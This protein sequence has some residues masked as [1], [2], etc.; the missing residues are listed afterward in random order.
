MALSDSWLKAHHKKPHETAI[1]KAD[2]EGLGVRVS[3]TG[4]IVFQMRYRFGGKPARLDLG[5]YPLLSLREARTEHQRLRTELER[6]RDP[7]HVRSSEREEVAKVWTNEQLYREWHTNYCVE[8]KLQADD[9]LRSFEIHVFPKLGKLPA[10]QT[11]A[12]QWLTLIETVA[13]NTPSIAERIL[14]T[15]KQMQKWA[16][17]RGLM[18]TKPLIDVSVAEDLMIQ[19]EPAGR[20]LSEEEIRLFWYGVEA[21]RMAPGTKIFLKLLLLFGCRGVELRELDPVKD[22]DMEA[23]VW[24]VP[25]EKNK[26]RK[27]VRRGISR[28]IIQEIRPLIDEAK[29]HSRSSHL[30]FTQEK[31]PKPLEVNATLSMPASVMRNVKRVYGVEMKHWSLYDLRKTARTNFSTLTDVHVAEVMLGHALQGM[32]G[33]YDRHLSIEEQA[34]AYKKWWDRIMGIVATPP[35]RKEA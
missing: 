25:P 3:A 32:Q 10:D 14:Q 4:K 2:G 29:R 11:T 30:L 17:R 35:K 27:R 24:T 34:A 12:H 7:R 20:A 19:K 5:T 18:K 26:V 28:P 16:H 21:S 23:G 31:A 8:N 33:V 1:E 9:Y 15:T 6:G 22:L 13:D